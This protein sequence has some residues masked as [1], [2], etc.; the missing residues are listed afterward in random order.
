M[1][2]YFLALLFASA[3]TS[4]LY[5]NDVEEV[6]VTSSFIDQTLSE[7]E[8]PIHVVSGQEI[9]TSA[10]QSLGESIDNLLGV[11]SADYGSGVGQPIIRGMS[12]ARIKVLNNGLVNRDVTGLG[13]DHINEID[14][15]NIQQ[16]EII[17]GPSSL[18]Y[19]NGAIG[20][21]INIVDNTIA[22][23]NFE[24]SKLQLG[25]ESQTVND[26]DAKS[27]S[28]ENNLGEINI[29]FNYKNYESG[30]FDIPFGALIHEED[31]H[32]NEEEQEENIG[33][34]NNSDYQTK[35]SRFG[36][37]KV[38][39]TGYFGVSISNIDSLYGIPFHGESHDEDEEEGH[40]QEEGHDEDGDEERIFITTKSDKIDVMGSININ[41][42]IIKKFDYYFRNTEYTLTEQ[43]AEGDEGH[44]EEGP[45]LFSNDSSEFGFT[46]DLSDDNQSEKIVLNFVDE[47]TSIVG[48]EVFMNPA[49][50]DKFTIGYYLSK[51]LDSFHL[52][53][54][55]RYDQI[56]TKGSVAHSEDERHD[57]DEENNDDHEEEA[58]IEYFDIKENNTSF[59]FSIGKDI[60]DAFD[61]SLGFASVERAPSAVELFMNG[62]HL[63]TGRFEV[64]NANLKSEKSNNFD[65][66]LNYKN[67]NFYGVASIFRNDVDNYIYLLDESEEQHNGYD[68]EEEEAH[69]EHGGLILSNY[70]QQDAKLDGY[71]IELGTSIEVG[72]GELD[73]S[74]GRDVVNGVFTDGHNIPRL[75]PSRNIY[76]L[77]YSLNDFL[78]K[79]TLK[80][81]G[82][83][84]DIGEGE[85]ST[86][87]YQMLNTK[88]MKTFSLNNNRKLVVSI[89][90]NNLLDEVARN[91]SSFVK[92][93]VPLP[94]RNYG[95]RFNL[96]L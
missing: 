23:K 42:P 1:N 40:D 77:A 15:N 65:I 64:G 92:N 49:Y 55:F 58:E 68:Q 39:E 52:D 32:G 95:L 19:S 50:N 60:N 46:I 5:A 31:E 47:D 70:L 80:G 33:Y 35:S 43:H 53:M 86:K 45:T 76:S 16:I 87:G 7:I 48:S 3:S 56:D 36:I 82:T 37:S 63:S 90:G 25:Y 89:F 41:A 81:V 12:G 11:S 51:Q 85:T 96:K 22:R 30:N 6:I 94:G 66:T 59:A 13:A 78:Y 26:G 67:D 44:K 20:G 72:N 38:G 57:K 61:L 84:S 73:L 18:L 75:N 79:L 54:G 27:L 10:S 9:T 8:N 4:N 17:R 93:E 24:E 2:K 74:I 88:L 71:E 91:H 28:Y 69:D 62:A 83:Q 21:I 29:T 14:F 34:L